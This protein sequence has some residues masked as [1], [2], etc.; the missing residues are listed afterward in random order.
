MS[1]SWRPFEE[2]RAFARGLKFKSR[3]EWEAYCR[4][5]NKPADIPSNPQTT[6]ADSGWIGWGDFLGNGNVRNISWRPFEEARPF[7]HGLKLK[8]VKE[9]GA[10]CKSGNRPDDI[11]SAPD[12]VYA[13][14]GWIGWGDWL[15]TGNV[16]S[17]SWRP[18]EEARTFVHGLKLKSVTEYRAYCK[19]GNKPDDIPTHP[20]I[21]YAD[22]GWISWY[23]WLGND[24][25]RLPRK[26][27]RALEEGPLA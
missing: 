12:V 10:Y 18:F 20:H 3:S 27:A 23:D 16:L 22:S 7:A 8:S 19:S 9:Y 24:N 26:Y 6:Y 17:K 25:P 4:S 2:A 13:D 15:G 1:K 14:S 11:P 5:G 21:I